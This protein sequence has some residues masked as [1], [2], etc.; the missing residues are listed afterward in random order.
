[1]AKPA[2]VAAIMLLRSIFMERA[3]NAEGGEQRRRAIDKHLLGAVEVFAI[4]IGRSA[5]GTPAATF[6][7]PRSPRR[8]ND[9]PARCR[10]I[11]SR[12]CR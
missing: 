2:P 4:V 5:T 6:I 10:A 12:P 1:M 9:E 3:I 8:A 7:G 11:R